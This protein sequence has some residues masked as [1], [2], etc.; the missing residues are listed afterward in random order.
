M[1]CLKAVDFHPDPRGGHL[2]LQVPLDSLIDVVVVREVWR[3]DD[4]SLVIRNRDNVS[5]RANHTLFSNNVNLE[6]G[7]RFSF[8]IIYTEIEKKYFGRKQNC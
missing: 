4:D 8:F 7:K 6:C 2:R 3:G 1:T 5:S